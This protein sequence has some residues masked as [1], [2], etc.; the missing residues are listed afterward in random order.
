MATTTEDTKVD[1]KSAEAEAPATEKEE[2][3]SAAAARED[4]GPPSEATIE[5]VAERLQFFFGNANL[6][7]DNFLR[8]RLMEN[9]NKVDVET[10]LKFNSIKSLT[11]S[12]EAIV[13]AA[14]TMPS[15]LSVSDDSKHVGRVEPFGEAN[16][17]E[18]IPLTL[19]LKN[20]PHENGAYHVTVKEIREFFEP[21]GEVTIVKLGF[22]H[23]K[24]KGR[25]PKGSCMVEFASASGVEAAAMAVATHRGGKEVDP[26]PDKKLVIGDQTVSILTLKDHLE[27]GAQDEQ[28]K[29]AADSGDAVDDEDDVAIEWKKGSVIQV[30]GLTAECDREAILDAIAKCLDCK[31]E[32]L[33]GKVYVDYSRGQTSGAI[34]FDDPVENQVS[35]MCQKL[36]SGEMQI[37]GSNVESAK[38]LGGDE[39]EKYWKGF[40]EFKKKQR[41]N[42]QDSGRKNKRRRHN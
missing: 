28:P 11:K 33:K 16:M 5:A 20:I 24:H 37:G 12:A 41:R 31:V 23:S 13:K 26:P 17:D 42:R 6:R 32:E 40:A 36:S 14:Q 3:G 8:K 38:V 1:S 22:S 27:F 15:F 19:F 2:S 34:R 29:E 18:H 7:K 25:K 21:Y 39:E 4:E 9:E 35:D 30:T 10:L